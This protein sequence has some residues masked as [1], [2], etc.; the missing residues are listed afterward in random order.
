M[1]AQ[2]PIR[3]PD[4]MIIRDR[5]IEQEY[6]VTDMKVYAYWERENSLNIV[7]QIFAKHLTKKFLL[8]CSLYDE[9]GDVLDSRQNETY[10]GIGF[11]TYEIN[12]D[13][14]FDGFP[15][16]FDVYDAAKMHQVKEIRIV[17]SE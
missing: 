15:F 13:T 5:K 1:S 6:G 11:V 8:V 16:R 14:F 3:V 4:N 17:L 10:G 9:D 2:M 7:G 12:P